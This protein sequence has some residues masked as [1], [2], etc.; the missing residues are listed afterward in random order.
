MDLE[1]ALRA[2]LGPRVTYKQPLPALNERLDLPVT[3]RIVHFDL[4]NGTPTAW[5]DRP[6]AGDLPAETHTLIVLGTGLQTPTGDYHH[7]GT[8]LISD[9]LVV[10]HLYEQIRAAS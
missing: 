2:S 7:R 4:Q 9:G 5:Y 6:A 3:S 1:P 8:A 10:L